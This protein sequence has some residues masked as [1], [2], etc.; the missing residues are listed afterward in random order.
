MPLFVN[1]ELIANVSRVS[2]QRRCSPRRSPDDEQKGS[3]AEEDDFQTD[4]DEDVSEME[5][6]N[7]MQTHKKVSVTESR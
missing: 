3:D 7:Q 2:L 4:D 1:N 6:E 5:V